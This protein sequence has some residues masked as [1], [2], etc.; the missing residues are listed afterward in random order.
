MSKTIYLLGAG[1][2][3]GIRND[4]SLI[5]EGLP[6]MDEIKRELNEF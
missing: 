4:E 3:Y 1:A 2:S 5:I 6:V